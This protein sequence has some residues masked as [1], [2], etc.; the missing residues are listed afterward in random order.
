M[1]ALRVILIGALSAFVLYACGGG[2]SNA[3]MTNA[4]VQALIAS[5]I[6]PLQAQVNTLQTQVNALEGQTA[7]AVFIQA[8]NGPTVAVKR[9]R[10]FGQ[11]TS[12]TTTSTC[13]GLGTLTG[14]PRSSDPI[15]SNNLSGI[16]CTGYYFT[17]S[18][19]ATSAQ[20]SYIQ[21]VAPEINVW[22]TNANCTGNPYVAAGGTGMLGPVSSGAIANGFVFTTIDPTTGNLVYWMLKAGTTAASAN[23]LSVQSGTAGCNPATGPLSLYAVVPNDQTVSG[24]PSAAIPG[25]VTIG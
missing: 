7:P 24:I 20:T 15:E 17:V 16:S 18:G 21:G 19:S 25:P 8:P 9:Q 13:T 5:A 14:R 12:T 4:Q 2:Q 23:V 6:A 11:K 1:K 3:G 22:W 10:N